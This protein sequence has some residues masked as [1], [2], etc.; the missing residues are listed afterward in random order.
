MKSQSLLAATRCGDLELRWGERTYVMGILNATPDSF[1]G[2][3]VG[4]DVGA[5]L[6]RARRMVEEGADIIDVGGESTRPG[7]QSV[8][9]DEEIRR[10][11]PV[12]E[13][14]LQEV[15]AALIIAYRARSPHYQDQAQSTQEMLADLHLAQTVKTALLLKAGILVTPLDVFAK[16]GVVIM[17]GAVPTMEDVRLCEQIAEEVEAYDFV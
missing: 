9:A 3:G 8:P 1:S 17:G 5:A 4:G 14:L 7:F 10:T 13:R 15:D 16:G 12:I 2:D 6:A 11:V